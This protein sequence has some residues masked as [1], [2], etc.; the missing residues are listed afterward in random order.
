ML[1]QEFSKSLNK[2]PLIS[3]ITAVLNGEEYL[4]QTIQSVINQSYKNVEYIII[5]D[6]STDNTLNIIKKY[7][8]QIAY[9]ESQTNSGLYSSWNKGLKHAKGEWICFLGSDDYFWALDVIEKVVPHLNK[10]LPDFRVVYGKNNFISIKDESIIMTHGA[11]WGLVKNNFMQTMC[12]PHPGLFHHKS[13]F[14]EYGE[15]DSSFKISGDY[16]FLLRELTH[17]DAYHINDAIVSGVRM[18]GMSGR[19]D[20]LILKHREIIKCKR[21]NGLPISSREIQ[22]GIVVY[23]YVLLRSVLGENTT[24]HLADVYRKMTGRPPIWSK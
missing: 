15:F 6:G 18:G 10:A 3:V 8:E 24:I 22:R 2:Q 14:K 23:G 5:N 17:R 16:D 20:N 9:W 11:E 13:L 7:D 19:L 4:E 12:I 1:N 21:K